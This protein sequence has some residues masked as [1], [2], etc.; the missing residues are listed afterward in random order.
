VPDFRFGDTTVRSGGEVSKGTPFSYGG[1]IVGGGESSWLDR[2]AGAFVVGMQK[3]PL[4]GFAMNQIADLTGGWERGD[5]ERY[6]ET[7]AGSQLADVFEVIGEWGPMLL[8]GA[9]VYTGGKAAATVGLKALAKGATKGQLGKVAARTADVAGGVR[10]AKPGLERGAEIAGGAAG[11]GTYTGSEEA[12]R[13]GDWGDILKHAAIGAGLT[14]GFEGSLYAVGKLV[15]ATHSVDIK[16]AKKMIRAGRPQ[17][18]DEERLLKSSVVQLRK[19]LDKTLATEKQNIELLE[20]SADVGLIGRETQGFFKELRRVKKPGIEVRRKLK[21]AQAARK[22]RQRMVRGFINVDDYTRDT[23]FNPTGKRA[24]VSA[25]LT[26]ALKTPE[27][28]GR[29]LGPTAVRIVQMAGRAE[30]EIA[31][32][33]ALTQTVAAGMQAQVRK[34]LGHRAWGSTIK[35]PRYR[36][37]FD[38]WERGGDEGI[39]AFLRQIGR[40]G[41]VSTAKELFDNVRGLRGVY[42]QLVKLGA[43]PILTA[44]DM[45]ALGV[46]EWLPH[47]INYT[48]EDALL[49]AM[50][51][52]FGGGAKGRLAAERYVERA[53]KDGLA[54]FGSI[55]HQRAYSGTLADKVRRFTQANDKAA[56]IDNPIEAIT[57]YMDQVGRRLAY[58]KRFGFSGELK[59]SMIRQSIAE[60]AS[61]GLINT[62]G[63]TLLG[64]KYSPAATRRLLRNITDM[65]T[66]TKLTLAVIPNM[67][68]TINTVLFA[69]YRATARGLL[70]AAVPGLTR[71]EFATATG[72]ANASYDI[73]KHMFQ[74]S[75]LRGSMIDRAFER[76][77]R[78]TLKWSGFEGVENFNRFVGGTSGFYAIN[79]DLSRAIAGRLRGNSLDRA[80][81]RMRTLD[82]N[83]DEMVG[84]AEREAARRGVRKEEIPIRELFHPE[85]TSPEGFVLE[86][87]ELD[88]AIFN[89]AKQT[90][91]TPDATRLPMWWQTPGGRVVFQFK[92]F[93]LSQGRFLRDQVFAEAARGNMKPLASF[94]A[95]YPIAGEAVGSARYA[96]RGKERP[97]D[98]VYRFMTNL[99]YVGGFGLAWDTLAAAK[100]GRLGETL[101]GPAVGDMVHLSELIIQGQG[102]GRFFERQ[103][104]A[105]AARAVALGGATTVQGILELVDKMEASSP[106]MDDSIP[107]QDLLKGAQ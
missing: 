31:H 28:L 46:R 69:G 38:A 50:T 47:V 67:S 43:E 87:G 72:I 32:G 77:A 66:A 8:A 93:A 75:G 1:T 12:A 98:H 78:G 91:F 53:T 27:G 49:Q 21:A 41:M 23:P 9:G 84:R 94:L 90:Q 76:A 106:E 25:F 40:P 13:G 59:D 6:A 5:I 33:R 16:D 101:M 63:D 52:H 56:Y 57:V 42:G 58:G 39:E 65:E 74:E 19:T 88:R 73:M 80:R 107:I 37:M 85:R 30:T 4:I 18:R 3:D 51:R 54:R 102:I 71:R 99:G 44:D 34:I 105:Q 11:I 45:A 86:M 60:G 70:H 97:G 68:Q 2:T 7:M 48:N 64:F 92:R 36:Q 61:P 79:R 62:I 95:I 83:L 14:A 15:R 96:I 17:R 81:R 22:Q 89:A 26:R 103:P 104:A 20:H 29:E 24:G 35:D 55:D 10:V 100:W 82:I